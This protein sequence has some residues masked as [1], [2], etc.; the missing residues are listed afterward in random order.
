MLLSDQEFIPE[1]EGKGRWTLY[2]CKD[3]KKEL[4]IFSVLQYKWL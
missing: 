3:C 2:P 1:I 4:K